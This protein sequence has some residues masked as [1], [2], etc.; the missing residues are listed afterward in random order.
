MVIAA[1]TAMSWSSRV[2]PGITRNRAQN[3][4]K[5]RQSTAKNQASIISTLLYAGLIFINPL[6]FAALL[7]EEINPARIPRAH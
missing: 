3:A 7:S 5:I 1:F 6:S 2:G 4:R